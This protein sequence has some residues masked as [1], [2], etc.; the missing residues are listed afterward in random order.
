MKRVN[1]SEVEGELEVELA[2]K[3]VGRWTCNARSSKLMHE[4]LRI[5]D[6]EELIEIANDRRTKTSLYKKYCGRNLLT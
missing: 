5:M 1:E 3:V 4:K 2:V 6:K